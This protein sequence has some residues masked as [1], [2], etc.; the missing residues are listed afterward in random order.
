[1]TGSAF[2]TAAKG[3]DGRPIIEVGELDY[4][5]NKLRLMGTACVYEGNVLIR[6]EDQSGSFRTWNVPASAG[7]PQRGD[8]SAEVVIADTTTRVVIGQEE[9]EESAA[10][11]SAREVIIPVPS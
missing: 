6:V 7:G 1:M 3:P 5:G 11:K 4:R 9:M 2:A 8:W 10:T